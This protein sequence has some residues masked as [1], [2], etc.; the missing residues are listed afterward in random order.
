MNEHTGL[1]SLPIPLD[2]YDFFH[3]QWAIPEEVWVSEDW[4]QI[5]SDAVKQ[6]INFGKFLARSTYNQ[7]STI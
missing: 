7:F 6:T 2:E 3:P 5:P 1:V 4:W